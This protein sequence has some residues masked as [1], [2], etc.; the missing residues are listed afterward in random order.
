[1]FNEEF[2]FL[3][4]MGDVIRVRVALFTVT[5]THEQ[6]VRGETA[7]RELRF[8]VRSNFEP[9]VVAAQR[10]HQALH[11]L[12]S[13]FTLRERS[14]DP[15]TQAFFER[16]LNDLETDFELGRLIV[17]EGAVPLLGIPPE[18]ELTK[19][20][21]GPPLEPP[22]PPIARPPRP[23]RLTSF[24]VR[25]VDE[26]GQAIGGLE[27]EFTAGPRVEKLTTNPAGVA[28]LEDV[29]TMSAA[30]SV[31]N[32]RE[33]GRTL[34]SRW[35][36]PRVGATPTGV[37]TKTF[38]FTGG[39]IAGVSLK[40][41]VP[42]T[43]VI[44]PPLGKLFVEL[45]DKSGKVLHKQQSYTI[46]GPQSFSGTTDDEGRLAHDEV[47]RGDYELTL[48][49]TIDVGAGETVTEVYKSP[50][51]V[52]ERAAPLPQLRMIGI[53]PRIVMARL[54]GMLFDTNKSFLLPTATE[55]L[56]KIRG[57]YLDNNPSELLIVGHTDTT[58]EPDVNEPLSKER[59]ESMKAYLEDDVDAWLK[60]YDLSGKKKWGSREDRLMITAMPDFDTRS[61]D[62]DIIEWFQ[63]TRGLEIDG[64]AG[65]KT[66]RQ[67]ITEYMALDGV[68]LAEEPNF[69]LNITT[70]GAGENFPLEDTGFDLDTAAADEKEDPF[71]R[72]VELFF[73]DPE[74]KILPAPGAPDGDEYLAWRERAAENHDFP[75]EGIGKKATVIEFQDALFRTNSCVML[76]EGEAP[77]PDEH[78]AVT[79]VGLVATTLRFADERRGK[80][81][82]IA[83]HADTTNTVDFNQPLSEERAKCV[84][85]VIEGNR[86]AFVELV[87]ARHTVADYKQILSWCAAAFPDLFSCDPGKIDDVEFT[88][89]EPLKVFQTNYNDHRE[90]LGAKDAEVLDVDGDIGPKTWGAI[91]DV[92][93]FALR[94]ELGE[95]EADVRALRQ[96]LQFVDDE[97]KA[98]GFSE[99]HPVD[100]IGRDGVRSQTNRR[101]EVLFF[102]KGEEPDLVL[103]ESD[104]DISEIYLPSEF[105]HV[106]ILEVSAKRISYVLTLLPNPEL[107][108]EQQFSFDMTG[109]QSASPVERSM[110]DATS[111]AD[112]TRKIVFKIAPVGNYTLRCLIGGEPL[113][114]IFRGIPVDQL[115]GAEQPSARTEDP[116]GEER[117]IQEVIELEQAYADAGEPRS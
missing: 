38:A 39:P 110:D 99:H 82:F 94:D 13:V 67:L 70:H 69:E 9:A 3:T 10:M 7:F 53:V 25:F 30:V 33:L 81:L 101:V 49:L 102:D 24:E 64:K 90:A 86:E 1:M 17:T 115:T 80:K 75:I 78:Q 48:S 92:Y 112:G 22:L 35:A 66:R 46:T 44:T 34:D 23:D 117:D 100:Q 105:Q 113:V 16:L 5:L 89:I 106:P 18:F 109:D 87:E 98:L 37:N 65:P 32:V 59:A 51:V 74:F 76:P 15:L 29:A 40:P 88:G 103:A 68:N 93:E 104:P 72:R 62:E 11:E 43:V 97:R 56:A 27:V 96:S 47:A 108:D 114:T 84:L 45:W 41:A 54:R 83:G 71:D 12:D 2:S 63:R 28:L 31:V 8:A 14:P 57:I 116:V 50:L 6:R 60:N 111:A 36:E 26:V 52:L 73:F 20:D 85:A 61:E 95:D 79:S 91:F 19:R 77:S 107:D 42:N 4:R 55:A 58:A 21:E